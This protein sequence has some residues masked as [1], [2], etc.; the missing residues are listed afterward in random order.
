MDGHYDADRAV[1][2]SGGTTT[3]AAMTARQAGPAWCS[4][5]GNPRRH[6][7]GRRLRP[8]RDGFPEAHRDAVTGRQESYAPADFAGRIL[9]VHPTSAQGRQRLD[10]VTHFGLGGR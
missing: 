10:Y 4:S 5:S 8:L 1:I 3:A 7:R 6:V 2:G 9:P